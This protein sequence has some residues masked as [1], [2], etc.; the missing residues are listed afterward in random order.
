MNQNLGHLSPGRQR[1]VRLIQRVNFGRVENL[2]IVGGE[3]VFKPAPRTVQ[4]VKLG[5]DN[6]QRTETGLEDFQLTSPVI[7]MLNQLTDLGDGRIERLDVRY[8]LPFSMEIEQDT[9]AA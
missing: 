4:T 5:G 7:D 1:L 3:P 2:L 6:D 9:Q 8:G